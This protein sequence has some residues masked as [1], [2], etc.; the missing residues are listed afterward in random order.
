[1][2]AIW[3]LAK[4]HLQLQ[5]Q[6]R[7]TYIQSFIVPFILMV[8]LALAISDD[9]VRVR[10]D[11]VDQDQSDYSAQLIASLQ[12]DAE[13]SEAIELC[14]Y[15]SADLP[16]T[17]GLTAEDEFADIGE[18]RVGSGET[19]AA[20]VIPAG[21][22]EALANGQPTEVLYQ[23][24]EQLNAPTITRTAVQTALN[25]LGASLTIAAI[26]T[27][28][29][30]EYFAPYPDD[31]A[32]QAAHLDLRSRAQTA[33]QTSYISL[34]TVSTG[35]EITPG[36]GANQSVPGMASMYV[37]FSLLSLAA[38]LVTERQ[39]GTLQRLFTVPTTRLNIVL[40]KI[41]GAYL[42][43]IIQFTIFVVMGTFLG[44]EWGSNYP[45]IALLVLAYCLAG[46]ALGFVLATLVKTPDQAGGM[47]T[48]IGLTLAP[49]GGAWWPL[50]IVP[51]TMRTIGHL[52]PIAWVMDGF[53]DVIY[54][55]GGVIDVLP[56][57][58]VLLAMAAVLITFA[59]WRFRYE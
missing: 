15:G 51:P 34:N 19:A 47:V 13:A 24:N 18:D 20:V 10:L 49:L 41:F 2:R 22:G 29:S 6:S 55:E 8:V 3:N 7:A 16:D 36:F 25:E 54:Y 30:A 37:L 56:E 40:G 9:P 14:V 26:G 27:E 53:R 31:A 58:G 57:V 32:Q 42:F 59:V 39:Q 21:F 17:C 12:A 43:G 46:T 50:E 48:L 52:S 33:L 35:K 23:S 4:L 28:T 44:T 5:L 38:V 1:M 45:A 11:V